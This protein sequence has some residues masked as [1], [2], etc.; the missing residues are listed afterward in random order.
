MNNFTK[1]PTHPHLPKEKREK[2][3]LIPQHKNL[4]KVNSQT[5][6]IRVKNKAILRK[7][8]L[9]THISK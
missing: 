3:K 6:I 5:N 8:K 4:L 9:L 2:G 1:K 7:A